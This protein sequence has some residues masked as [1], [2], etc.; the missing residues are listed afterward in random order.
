MMSPA[1]DGTNPNADLVIMS[2]SNPFGMRGK[3]F[4]NERQSC[5]PYLDETET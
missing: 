3:T 4:N 1:Q 2:R 5:G